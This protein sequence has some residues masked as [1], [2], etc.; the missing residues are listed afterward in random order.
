MKNLFFIISIAFL[1]GSVG[2]ASAQV[3][4]PDETIAYRMINVG[5]E[6][7]NGPEMCADIVNGGPSN[8][9][10]STQPCANY[11]S[12]IWHIT[13]TMTP[14]RHLPT[15]TLTTEFRGRNM[16]LTTNDALTDLRL[17]ACADAPTDN[18]IWVFYPSE[19]ATFGEASIVVQGWQIVPYLAEAKDGFDGFSL[20]VSAPPEG[21]GVP[22][23]DKIDYVGAGFLWQLEAW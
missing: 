9:E 17:A 16:C 22:Y 23:I 10:M 12:Q 6:R 21:D 1:L 7:L 8:N 18:Q 2:A 14:L 19:S 3:S 13:G 15:Y 4:G 11:S 5:F 20:V